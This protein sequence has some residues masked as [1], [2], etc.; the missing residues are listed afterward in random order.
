[1]NY[2]VKGKMIGGFALVAYPAIYSASGVMTL[3]CSRSR[4][5]PLS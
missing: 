4:S 3:L 1:M 5:C 2:V